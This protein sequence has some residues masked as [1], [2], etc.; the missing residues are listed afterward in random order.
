MFSPDIILCGWLG[1]KHQLYNKLTHLRPYRFYSAFQNFSGKHIHRL[2]CFQKC[3]ALGSSMPSMWLLSN[4]NQ[5]L[6]L[7]CVVN[8]VARLW[9]TSVIWLV[10]L[11]PVGFMNEWL[12]CWLTGW[13][14]WL[15]G[16]L[17]Y[18]I[19]L[20][21]V[22]RQQVTTITLR[23]VRK[24]WT[25]WRSMLVSAAVWRLSRTS[26]LVPMKI[27]ESDDAFYNVFRC[28]I[29]MFCCCFLGA[30]VCVCVCVEGNG[31]GGEV[32]F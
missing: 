20:S 3:S 7:Y 9:T 25:T 23:Q 22:D 31:G 21:C 13:W 24:F 12:T 16:W 2:P 29:F 17:V 14:V 30:C 8:S 27:S 11:S 28:F 1:S 15:T 6:L 4:S 5:C 18:V 26:K 10:I 32:F 19:T